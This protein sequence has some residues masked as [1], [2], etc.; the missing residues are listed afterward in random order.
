MK[1]RTLLGVVM[2]M[3]VLGSM[4]GWAQQERGQWRAASTTAKAITGDVAIAG[5]KLVINFAQFPIAEIRALRPEEISAAFNVEDATLGKG[6]LYRL[7]VA[8]G[9]RFLH[10]NT[11][12]GSDETQWMATYVQ[13]KDLQLAFFSG[14]NMPQITPEA[15]GNTTNLCGTFSYVR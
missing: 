6:Y 11:L 10:K 2:T 15:L 7:S 5:E 1:R 14:G 12:C 3:A 9:Q 13:G 4:T 8:P